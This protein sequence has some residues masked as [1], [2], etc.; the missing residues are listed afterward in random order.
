MLSIASLCVVLLVLPAHSI[1]TDPGPL[2]TGQAPT[3]TCNITGGDFLEWNYITEGANGRI[4]AYGFGHNAS[5]TVERSG[6]EFTV[7]VLTPIIPNL[8][9]QIS[10]TASAV[11]NSRKLK[12]VGTVESMLVQKVINLQVVSGE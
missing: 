11:M 3:L 10:F 12:C 4:P 2:C 9:S 5:G 6:V 7:S 8:V 1:L